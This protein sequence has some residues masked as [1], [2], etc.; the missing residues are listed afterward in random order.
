MLWYE[1]LF[2]QAKS[3]IKYDYNV[4]ITRVQWCLM[5][6]RRA[7]REGGLT[8]LA[9]LCSLV[10]SAAGAP[11]LAWL[12]WLHSTGP[13]GVETE[14]HTD[15]EQPPTSTNQLGQTNQ[16]H[17]HSNWN[18]KL[19]KYYGEFELN[20]AHL[21]LITVQCGTKAKVTH[22]WSRHHDFIFVSQPE[23]AIA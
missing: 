23:P 7:G 21:H 17:Q 10:M 14:A 19:V 11:C 16:T 3:P 5:W 8:P 18:C 12:C 2:N 15:R 1:G 20:W 4:G 22:H 9:V 6:E 13:A